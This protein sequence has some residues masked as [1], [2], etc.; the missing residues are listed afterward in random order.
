EFFTKRSYDI[1]IEHHLNVGIAGF[2]GIRDSRVELLYDTLGNGATDM[3]SHY[4]KLRDRARQMART[5]LA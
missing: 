1:M 4:S 2:C 5:V 3:S